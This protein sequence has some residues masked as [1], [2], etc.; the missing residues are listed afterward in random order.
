MG[1]A[2]SSRVLSSTNTKCLERH[3]YCGLEQEPV[4]HQYQA[5]SQKLAN[6]KP[7]RR[8]KRRRKAKD[9]T[10]LY[11]GRLLEPEDYLRWD[12]ILIGSGVVFDWLGY[13]MYVLS[14]TNWFQSSPPSLLGQISEDARIVMRLH[15]SANW[16]DLFGCAR[17]PI[18]VCKWLLAEYPFCFHRFHTISRCNIP[19]WYYGMF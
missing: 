17:T 15:G 13:P 1:T 19:R 8:K 18:P 9:D 7:K 6:G 12:R 2:D 11:T 3:E 14:R 5:S 10:P 16:K 4:Q